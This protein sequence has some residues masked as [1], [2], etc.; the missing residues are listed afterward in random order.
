[1]QKRSLAYIGNGR[2]ATEASQA[3]R[4]NCLYL[5]LYYGK[6]YISSTRPSSRHKMFF[7]LGRQN[8]GGGGM[9]IQPLQVKEVSGPCLL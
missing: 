9:D 8:F 7:H 3:P 6:G 5:S 2:L 4:E 1:M